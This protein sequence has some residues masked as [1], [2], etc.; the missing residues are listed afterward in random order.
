[1]IMRNIQPEN[2]DKNRVNILGV[3][4]SPIDIGLPL[5]HFGLWIND[6]TSE[7]VCIT[8]VHGVMESQRSPKLKS[9][10]NHAGM[11]TPDGMPLVWLCRCTGIKKTQRVYGPGPCCW[12]PASGP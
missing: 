1:M 3:G 4:V 7:Y 2:K 12:L 5:N 10:H 6:Q 8:G 9:I 11:V